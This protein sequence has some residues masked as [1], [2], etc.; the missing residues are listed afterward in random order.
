MLFSAFNVLIKH[1]KPDTARA[2]IAP[3]ARML[4]I[5][6]SGNPWVLLPKFFDG[7]QLFCG[8]NEDDRL[9][10]YLELLPFWHAPLDGDTLIDSAVIAVDNAATYAMWRKREYSCLAA[11]CS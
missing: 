1:Y 8:T 11:F 9:P 5:S 2:K 6:A 4:G 7:L 3:V 10:L